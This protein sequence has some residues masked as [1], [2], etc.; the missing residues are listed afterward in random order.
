MSVPFQTLLLLLSRHAHREMI[1][2]N[3]FL[4]VQNEILR[5]K[6]GKKHIVLNHAER[7]RMRSS[8]AN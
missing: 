4:K 7:S 1:A 6:L 3:Q 2:E 5:Q 8:A